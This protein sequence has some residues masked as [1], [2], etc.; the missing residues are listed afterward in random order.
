MHVR[1]KAVCINLFMWI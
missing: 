1:L